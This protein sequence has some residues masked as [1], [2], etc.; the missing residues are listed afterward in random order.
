MYRKDASDK[1]IVAVIKTSLEYQQRDISEI[2]DMLKDFMKR[3]ENFDERI[4]K[5]EDLDIDKCQSRCNNLYDEM[6][7]I[8]QISK[9]SK[10]FW[11]KTSVL[12]GIIA[13]V[14]S[15]LVYIIK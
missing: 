6:I 8:K 14:V 7:K 1:E 3:S 12:I 10:Y 5:M 2:K 11:L 13:S 4:Q 9:T 15:V